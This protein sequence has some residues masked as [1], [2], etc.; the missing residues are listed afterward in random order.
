MVRSLT[1]ILCSQNVATLPDFTDDEKTKLELARLSQDN[2][3]EEINAKRVSVL[4]LLERF[5]CWRS[6]I[7]R[8]GAICPED[9]IRCGNKRDIERCPR[10]RITASRDKPRFNAHIRF[11]LMH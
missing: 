9:E 11:R 1:I 8:I 5:P 2:Y 3:A 7:A 10:L 6:I 4:D